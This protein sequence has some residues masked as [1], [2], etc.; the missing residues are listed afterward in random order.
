MC[1]CVHLR[2]AHSNSSCYWLNWQWLWHFRYWW[3]RI[4]QRWCGWV[5]AEQ[6]S[7][8]LNFAPVWVHGSC[9]P[10]ASSPTNPSLFCFSSILSITHCFWRLVER[11]LV[12][13]AQI[14]MVMLLPSGPP[15]T[16]LLLYWMD[17]QLFSIKG[18][19]CGWLEECGVKKTGA[20][21][22]FS[23]ITIMRWWVWCWGQ[24]RSRCGVCCVY[25]VPR[26]SGRSVCENIIHK[27]VGRPIETIVS[28]SI[29]AIFQILVVLPEIFFFLTLLRRSA[30]ASSTKPFSNIAPDVSRP[31]STIQTLLN[32]TVRPDTNQG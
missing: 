9:H 19:G 16:Y 4:V 23:C 5:V 6:V 29:M 8:G 25:N 32:S 31:W 14:Q 17:L 12:L 20:C 28:T 7:S 18:L 21:A 30:E 13:S 24:Y 26:S 15:L 3:W 2:I 1:L 27:V 11:W 22:F 10:C